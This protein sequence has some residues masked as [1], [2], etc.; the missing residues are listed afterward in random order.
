MIGL[1]F[2]EIGEMLYDNNN[3]IRVVLSSETIP[4]RIQE[5][6]NVL[7]MLSLLVYGK[8]VGICLLVF[9]FFLRFRFL[10]LE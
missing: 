3:E 5:L 2:E 10:R 6:P 4:L 7:K 1:M 8:Q 9:Y